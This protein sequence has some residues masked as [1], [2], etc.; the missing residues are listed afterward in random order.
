MSSPSDSDSR[1]N[2]IFVPIGTDIG[3]Q[4]AKEGVLSCTSV[5]SA[6]HGVLTL[7]DTNSLYYNGS[8]TIHPSFPK[9]VF[10]QRRPFWTNAE[11]VEI[12]HPRASKNKTLVYHGI[13]RREIFYT[14]LGL[15]QRPNWNY[16]G[17][18]FGSG[19][20]FTYDPNIA[21]AYAGANG[22][23]IAVDWSREGQHLSKKILRGEEWIS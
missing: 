2:P 11:K 20:Y 13:Q 22:V 6:V 14:S 23:L 9:K 5:P 21:K 4:R 8:S 19:I 10:I 7:M 3:I 17:S 18:E 12:V 16:R 1:R 15:G